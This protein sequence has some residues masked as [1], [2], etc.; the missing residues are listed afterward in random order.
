MRKAKPPDSPKHRGAPRAT[1]EPT[2]PILTAE[3]A[4]PGRPPTGAEVTKASGSTKQ[5][6][7][8]K[9]VD[10][11]YFQYRNFNVVDRV[12]K[13]GFWSPATLATV[14][15][16]SPRPEPPRLQPHAPDPNRRGCSTR[17]ATERR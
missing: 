11:I 2:P 1:S 3:V 17:V 7:R 16:Q 13:F 8:P 4:A 9:V 14:L 6:D 12:A 10:F 5:P 15:G